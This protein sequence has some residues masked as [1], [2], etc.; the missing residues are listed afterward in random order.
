MLFASCS[1]PRRQARQERVRKDVECGLGYV[2]AVD[3]E[4][5]GSVFRRGELRGIAVEDGASV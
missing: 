2:A 1:H 5:P 3:G 4:D